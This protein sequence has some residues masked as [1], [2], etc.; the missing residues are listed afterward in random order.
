VTGPVPTSADPL[1]PLSGPTRRGVLRVAGLSGASAVLLAACGGDDEG[2]AGTSSDDTA[3][4]KAGDKA[5]DET[6]EGKGPGTGLVAV[7]DVPVG[8][9]VILESERIVITQPTEGDIKAFTA[10]CT[11]QACTVAS[12]KDDRISCPCHGSAYSAADGSVLN[13]PASRPLKS[14]PVTVEGDQVV[15]A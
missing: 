12:V 11:H 2:S 13:G 15:T 8:G 6:P 9:G 14:I 4:D 7:A 5:A 3:S 1:D 10:V